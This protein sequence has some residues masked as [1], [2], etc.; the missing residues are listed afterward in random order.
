MVV[1][2]AAAAVL[3]GLYAAGVF[4][5]SSSPSSSGP[6][7]GGGGGGGSGSGETFDAAAS[8]SNATISS[9]PP[10]GG[11]WTLIGGVAVVIGSS[12]TVNQTTLNQTA[13]EGNCNAHLLSTASSITAI[14]ATSPIKPASG[15]SNAWIV[16]YSNSTFGVLEMA[17]FGGT[18]TPVLTTST[19]GSCGHTIDALGLPSGYENSPTAASDAWGRGG[20]NW[21]AL[22]PDYDIELILAPGVTE[23]TGGITTSV[24]GAW[25]VSYTTCDLGS[26]TGKTLNNEAVS[27]FNVAFYGQNGSY[28]YSST[29]AIACP[30][31]HSGSGGGGGG[32][33]GGKIDLSSCYGVGVFSQENYT[34]SQYWNNGTPIC[35][36]EA[37]ALTSGG[38]TVSIENN[39]TKTAVS[40]TGFVL[41]IQNYSTN[42]VLAVYNFA[43]NSWNNTK[44]SIFSPYDYS[45]FVLVTSSSMLGNNIVFTATPSGPATGSVSSPLGGP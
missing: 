31:T 7:G 10:A 11:P 34:S 29:T 12:I 5:T 24:P 1:V 3:G 25:A 26:G 15:L 23:T 39:T 37:N 22:Y 32:G 38:V 13:S 18:A 36:I 45:V 21:T 20:D 14:P 16:L 17:V 8:A 30:V 44:V 40:T 42:A 27:Q 19:Y 41:Q 9:A 35:A 33:G 2:V 28:A 4:S 43:T 6:G